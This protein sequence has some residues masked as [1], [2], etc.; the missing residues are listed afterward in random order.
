LTAIALWADRPDILTV[1]NIYPLKKCFWVER[2]RVLPEQTAVRYALMDLGFRLEQNLFCY[3]VPGTDQIIYLDAGYTNT[4]KE[5]VEALDSVADSVEDDVKIKKL[6]QLFIQSLGLSAQ[7]YR[8][9]KARANRLI[10]A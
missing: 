1:Q 9:Q 5:S 4:F 10:D 3:L 2:P 6:L 7:N 8:D